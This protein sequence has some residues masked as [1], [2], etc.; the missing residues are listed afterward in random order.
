ML[1]RVA[2]TRKTTTSSSS[3]FWGFFFSSP[4][5]LY[6]RT[7]PVT[8]RQTSKRASS[9]HTILKALSGKSVHLERASIKECAYC[10]L[11]LWVRGN[12]YT[13]TRNHFCD[14][15]RAKCHQ[16]DFLYF[17]S[18]RKCSHIQNAPGGW[19]WRVLRMRN[20]NV[21]A[22]S[23]HNKTIEILSKSLIIGRMNFTSITTF[24]L[25]EKAPWQKI[26]TFKVVQKMTSV[27]IVKVYLMFQT[28]C[29]SQNSLHYW[30]LAFI[31]RLRLFPIL[32]FQH[33]T[34]QSTLHK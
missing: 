14:G 11:A 1:P 28:C 17:T 13:T 20:S 10:H 15:F 2:N 30:N 4:T 23:E 29:N 21:N 34:T 33:S 32:P 25:V 5:S 26:S 16:M 6:A 22:L 9:G 8:G 12:N 31:W 7:I 27:S 19:F 18:S 3:N 24:A